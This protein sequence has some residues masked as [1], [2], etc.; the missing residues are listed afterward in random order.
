VAEVEYGRAYVEAVVFE[1]ALQHD[2]VVEVLELDGQDPAIPQEA[3]RPLKLLGQG[4][5]AHLTDQ[6]QH[7]AGVVRRAAG[8]LAGALNALE[9]VSTKQGE[10]I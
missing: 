8:G 4:R 5:N 3:H 10:K 9:I 1:P 6:N 2:I 7:I